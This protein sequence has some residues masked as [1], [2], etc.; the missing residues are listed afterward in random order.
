MDIMPILNSQ[1]HGCWC[2]A[3][4]RGGGG[5]VR[6]HG[7][8]QVSQEYS[9]FCIRRV[10]LLAPAWCG[11]FFKG[12]S[13]KLILVTDIFN[14]SSTVALMWMPQETADEKSSLVQLIA[15][16]HQAPIHYLNQW[17]LNSVVPYAVTRLQWVNFTI[18]QLICHFVTLERH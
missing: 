5:G 7:I 18:L 9:R 8:H 4:R 12:V 1:Y 16:F 15:W 10:D 3:N 11:S 6:S 17:W 2:P 13:F 14:I